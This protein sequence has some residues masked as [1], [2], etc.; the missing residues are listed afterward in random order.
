MTSEII[1]FGVGAMGQRIA[2][3]ASERGHRIRAAIDM[4]PA[5]RGVPL[6]RLAGLADP[7][8]GPAITSEVEQA[9]RGTPATVLHAT[10]SFLGDV[11]DEIEICLT[12][13][14]D[15][16][17]IA[18]EMTCPEAASAGIAAQLEATAKRHDAR[19]LGTGVNP[20]FAMDILVLALTVPY[21]YY[22]Y[23]YDP[24]NRISEAVRS[25][26]IRRGPFAGIWANHERLYETGQLVDLLERAGFLTDVVTH[27]THYCF[28]GTQTIVYTLGKGLIDRNLL[29]GFIARSTHR[30]EGESGSQSRLNPLNWALALFDWIDRFNESDER[31]AEKKTFVNIAVRAVRI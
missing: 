13:G 18:E 29:P 6:G 27:L 1:I 14:H 16:I 19:V 12:H 8:A 2:R 10:A 24:I 9:L 20:G 30:F 31:L 4:D 23:W 21:R 3:L 26:P 28:P 15:V 11:A 5:K 17:S 7:L 25:R 22:P